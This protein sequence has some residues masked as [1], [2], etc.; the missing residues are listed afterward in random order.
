MM[1][2]Y[3][4]WRESRVRFLLSAAVLVF[5]CLGLMQRAR[6]GFPPPERPDLPYSAWVW[7]NIYGN[8]NPTVFVILVMI[9]G[10]GGLQRERPIGTAPFTLT[11]PVTRVRLV[12]V[13]A[14]MGLIQVAVLSLIPVMLV[15]TLSPW[16]ARQSYPVT[17]AF[18]FALLFMIWGAVAFAVG[19]VWSSVFGGEFTG[20]ALCVITPVVYR[21]LVSNSSR[22]QD[23]PAFNYASFMSG[24]PYILSPVKDLIVK[25]LPWITFAGLA[26]VT[27]ALITCAAGITH[28]QDF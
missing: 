16:I 27:I 20:T 19:F 24:L 3:K 14:A 22:L 13:R 25:P 26:A 11:L 12:F 4:A 5:L 10:L 8:L 1:L 23:F 21:I 15:P 9:L 17:Q 2:W 6:T 7:A 18:Q 28:Q